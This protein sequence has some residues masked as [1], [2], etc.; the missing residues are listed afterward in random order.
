[1][2]STDDAGR[3]GLAPAGLIS[4]PTLGLTPS[5]EQVWWP[6][7]TDRRMAGYPISAS[8]EHV[9]PRHRTPARGDAAGSG[10][11]A[12]PR[13]LEPMGR[14]PCGGWS[15]RD[16]D[17]S[18]AGVDFGGAV[19]VAVCVEVHREVVSV[20]GLGDLDEGFGVD[21]ASQ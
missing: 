8:E 5:V 20:E 10:P 13:L 12:P 15:R 1:M 16:R 19:A 2:G 7:R 4:R 3:A 17:G 9:A 18:I 14:S 21:G 6:S 11:S